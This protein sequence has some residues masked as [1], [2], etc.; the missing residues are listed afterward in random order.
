[1]CRCSELELN[2]VRTKMRRRSA[3]MQLL[4][5]MSTSRYLPPNGTAGL[6][7]S[8]VRGKRRVPAPPPMITATSSD[9]R[10][11]GTAEVTLES[12]GRPY[13]SA[14]RRLGIRWLTW[15]PAGRLLRPNTFREAEDV[16]P[17]VVPRS[18]VGHGPSSGSA[19]RRGHRGVRQ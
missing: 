1:M 17:S 8:F 18:P 12:Y 10:G 2:W 14:S 13:G 9:G 19:A 16:T 7:R 5:G 3:L 11:S 4:I 15:G 6:A